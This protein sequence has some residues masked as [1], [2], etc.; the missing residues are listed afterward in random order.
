MVSIIIGYSCQLF[1]CI[2]PP[3][4]L[5]VFKY[6]TKVIVLQY[7]H[8]Y[9]TSFHSGLQV[10]YIDYWITSSQ[11]IMSFTSLPPS[12]FEIPLFQIYHSTLT[13]PASKWILKPI[14]LPPWSIF[15]VLSNITSMSMWVVLPEQSE[16]VHSRS[17]CKYFASHLVIIA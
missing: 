5:A 1:S 17:L 16:M 6:S 9:I 15:Q 8:A 2:L 4:W 11:Q 3:T 7:Q 13:S 10:S 12:S 14:Q